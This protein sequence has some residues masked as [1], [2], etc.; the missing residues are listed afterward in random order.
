MRP[1]FHCPPRMRSSI[2]WESCRYFGASVWIMEGP[3]RRV[4][5]RLLPVP[6]SARLCNSAERYC[7]IF[8]VRGLCSTDINFS[9]FLRLLIVVRLHPRAGGGTLTPVRRNVVC[10]TAQLPDVREGGD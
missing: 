7:V 4:S 9:D 1:A 3:R 2:C 5:V 8:T 6:R 10:D